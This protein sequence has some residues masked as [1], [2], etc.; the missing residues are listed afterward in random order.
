MKELKVTPVETAS[1]LRQ[2]DGWLKKIAAANPAGLSDDFVSAFGEGY[3]FGFMDQESQLTQVRSALELAQQQMRALN[4][5]AAQF[6]KDCID[7]R[8]LKDSK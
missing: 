8:R 5:E 6:R 7:L 3:H 4:E 1:L 2:R